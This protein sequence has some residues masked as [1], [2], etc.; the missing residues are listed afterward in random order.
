MYKVSSGGK[1]EYIYA[2]G[3]GETRKKDEAVTIYETV[4]AAAVMRGGGNRGE[5]EKKRW[6]EVGRGDVVG[7]KG[8]KSTGEAGKNS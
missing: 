3:A 4:S 1:R 5:K 2:H 6:E 8:T 7:R